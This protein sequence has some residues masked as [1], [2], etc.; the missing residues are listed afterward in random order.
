MDAVARDLTMTNGANCPHCGTFNETEK[1]ISEM[2]T[3]PAIPEGEGPTLHCESCGK[4]F[5][6]GGKKRGSS[7]NEHGRERGA[8]HRRVGRR[9]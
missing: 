2:E 6:T 8:R 5:E 4:P 1:P 9:I 7:R 3:H